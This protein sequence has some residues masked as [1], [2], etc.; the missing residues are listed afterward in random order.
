MVAVQRGAVG[1]VLIVRLLYLTQWFDP[2]PNVVKGIAFVRALIAAGHEVTVV[3]GL[4]NYPTGKLYPGYRLRPFQREWI[5]GI[6]IVRL[7]LYPSHDRSSVRRSLKFVCVF[8]SVLLYCLF[9]RRAFD[10]AY[11]YHP[12][13]TVGL[14]AAIAGIVRPLPYVLDVQDLWPDTVAATGMPGADRL[15]G[16][17]GGLCAFVYRRAEAIIV[18]SD[19]MHRA[20]ASRNVPHS[21]LTTIYNWADIEDLDVLPTA[22]RKGGPFRLVYAGNLGRAQGIETIIDAGAIIQRQCR[23]VEILLYGEGVETATLRD[24]AAALGL[25]GLRFEDRIPR[26]RIIPILAQADALVMHLADDPLFAITIPSKTQFYLGI[27]RPIVAGVAGEAAAMLRQAGM[28]VVPPG[29]SA[30]LALAINQL[31][32]LPAGERDAIGREG[33]RYYRERLSFERGMAE[34]LTVL[35]GIYVKS[36]RRDP[37]ATP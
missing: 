2:E 14:A 15:V 11:V 12:P 26:Q 34:T 7:P 4:P 1:G 21:R 25:T 28:L 20:L 22:Q 8:V 6:E 37:I 9:H 16:L 24:R 17:L 29:D 33:R 10:L 27:G 23:D 36:R 18:Q 32:E 13:I 35:R 5:D 19:G 3:T 31:A 30:A